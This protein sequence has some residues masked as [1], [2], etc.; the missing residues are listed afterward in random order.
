MKVFDL[1]YFIDILPLVLKGLSA[2][3]K[4]TAL[5]FL[6]GLILG[7]LIAL[8]YN[9]KI[10]VLYPLAQLYVSIFRGTPVIAQM[11]F[12]YFGLPHFITPLRGMDAFAAASM[13]IA[14][15][16][17]S[18]MSETIRS[19]I[20]AVEKGQFE[21]GL[22]VGMT[23]FQVARRIILPQAGR[24]ALPSLSNNLIMTLKGTAVAFTIGVTEV[25]GKAKIEASNSY[26]YFECYAAAML[27]YWLVVVVITLFQG[28]WEKHLN[29]AYQ[30]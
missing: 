19:S 29:R 27:V 11:F 22:S 15:N 2:A 1:N 10:K 25:M 26:R 8:I 6:G 21:A 9:S 20:S 12:I 28:K 23:N 16:I 3:M 7:V 17:S 13:T 5:S 30:N 18:Y 24:I 14:L 4:M